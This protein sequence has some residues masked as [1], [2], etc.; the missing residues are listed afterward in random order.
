ME[1]GIL[2]ELDNTDDER[3]ALDRI[4]MKAHDI[5][6]SDIGAARGTWVHALTEWAE[7]ELA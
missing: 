2:R 4:A 3:K 1:P 6:G 5:A 7:K